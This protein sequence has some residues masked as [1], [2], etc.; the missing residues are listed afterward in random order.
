MTAYEDK[1][2]PLHPTCKGC[3]HQRKCGI[4]EYLGPVNDESLRTCRDRGYA[5]RRVL[6]WSAV[7]RYNN[8]K[9]AE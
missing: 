1:P 3:I 7:R 6:R 2:L 8:T 9:G 5:E 4:C